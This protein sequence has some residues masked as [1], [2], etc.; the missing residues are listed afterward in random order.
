MN[1]AIT[2]LALRLTYGSQ[3]S[4]RREYSH[5]FVETLAKAYEKA[6][7]AL[8]YRADNLVRRAAIERILKRLILIHKDPADVA[9]NLLTELKWARY[10]DRNQTKTPEKITLAKILDKYISYSG[11]IP[12]EWI[13]K[14]ASAEIEDHFNLNKDYSQ[15]TFYAFQV[16]KQ[17]INLKNENLELLIYFAVDKVFA[18]SDPE[19]IA[20]HIISLS[21]N[22]IDKDKMEEGWRLFNIAL[23]DKTLPRLNKFVRRIMPPL[24]LLRDIYFYSPSEFKEL[25]DN[26]DKF[27]SRASE[28][29]DNQL[30]QM[31]GKISTAGVRSIIY[32]F[33]TK[34]IFAFGVETPLESLVYGKVAIFPLVTNLLFPPFLMWITTMQI[35]TPSQDERESLV[36]RT[37]FVIE[38]FDSLKDEDDALNENT[39]GQVLG[40]GYLIFSILYT[41]IFISIFVL[42]YYV[43][44][45]IG[46]RFFSKLIFIF[47]LTIIAFFAYKINQIA[48]VY[49][50]KE[51]KESSTIGDTISLPILTIGSFLSQGLTKLNFLGF[52]FDFILEAP[53]KIILGFVDDWVQFLSSKKEDQSLE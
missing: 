22:D 13:V 8:E 11:T 25:L 48:R 27:I 19:Q 23:T 43:L 1:R 9:D 18:S 2:A 24:V 21:G 6:R 16:I 4:V 32:V 51:R 10:L 29:L 46:F 34:M 7:N 30:N 40:N 35:K 12:H 50:W 26:K 39:V 3:N 42:I 38:N 36:Q 49:S 47:F 28:V 33:L 15:F 31:S 45:L 20:Y 44:G 37:W 41:L 5:G 53:F 14:I 52:V 17:K